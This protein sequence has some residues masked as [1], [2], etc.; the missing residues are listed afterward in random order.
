MLSIEQYCPKGD[1]DMTAPLGP[2]TRF[3][4]CKSALAAHC[5]ATCKLYSFEAKMQISLPQKSSFQTK[6]GFIP[7]KGSSTPGCRSK[8]FTC[9]DTKSPDHHKHMGKRLTTLGCKSASLTFRGSN[10]EMK[11]HVR[12]G[13]EWTQWWSTQC[14]AV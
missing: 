14:N 2:Q 6:L 10:I 4:Q 7:T 1:I 11:V 13:S 9:E 12:K 3:V 8:K 5:K